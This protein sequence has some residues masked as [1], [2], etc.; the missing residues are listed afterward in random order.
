MEKNANRPE[1]GFDEGRKTPILTV[2]DGLVMRKLPVAADYLLLSPSP[3]GVDMENLGGFNRSAHG[4]LASGYTRLVVDLSKIRCVSSHFIDSLR[5]I[6]GEA[7]SRGGDIVLS[8]LNSVTREVFQK[9]HLEQD[10]V[11]KPDLT[12]ALAYL[13]TQAAFPRFIECPGCRRRLRVLRPG[14]HRCPAC[15]RELAVG[16]AGEP[17]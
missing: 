9:L 6:R 11:L 5:R 15:G 8:S 2:H 17:D 14:R 1:Q 10:H 13:K 3:L 4:A 12:E 7:R 16:A